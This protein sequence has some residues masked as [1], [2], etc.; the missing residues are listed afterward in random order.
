MPCDF[1]ASQQARKAAIRRLE[2][3]LKMKAARIAKDAL[4]AVRIE[5]WT[6]DRAGFCDECAVAA[7]RQSTD[8]SVRMMVSAVAAEGQTHSH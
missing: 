7:L 3:Q 8:L 6:G 1:R 2:A 4:G 5:G